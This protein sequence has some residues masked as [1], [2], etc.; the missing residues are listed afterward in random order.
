MKNNNFNNNKQKYYHFNNK[1]QIVN[2]I[3]I[4]IYKQLNLNRMKLNKLYQQMIKHYNSNKHK[5]KM[6][7]N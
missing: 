4:K 7:N 2:F 5:F 1:N 6:N 3:K